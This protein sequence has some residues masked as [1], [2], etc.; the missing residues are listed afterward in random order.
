MQILQGK[1]FGSTACQESLQGVATFF[2]QTIAAIHKN[3]DTVYMYVMY[4]TR[5]PTLFGGYQVNERLF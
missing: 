3:T 1:E 5:S 4:S 2:V